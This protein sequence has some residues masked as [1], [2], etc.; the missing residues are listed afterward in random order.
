MVAAEPPSAGA[1]MAEICH[2]AEM[3]AESEAAADAQMSVTL[4]Q[5]AEHPAAQRGKSL[6]D[7]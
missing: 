6:L 4:A 3:I 7:A 1:P 2:T 5:A